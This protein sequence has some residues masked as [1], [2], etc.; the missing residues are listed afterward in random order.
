MYTVAGLAARLISIITLAAACGTVQG[1]VDFT[2]NWASLYHEDMPERLPG[3][4]L[5]DSSGI[6]VNAAARLRGDSYDA[7]RISA[8]TEYQCR[9]HGGDYSMRGL[10]NMRVEQV[11]DPFSQRLVAIKTRMNFQDMQ[12]TIWLDGREHPDDLAP[13]TW[14]GFST[15]TWDAN[16]LNVYTTHLKQNYLRRNGLPRSDKATFTEHWVRHGDYLTV[17][18]VI[19]DP[20]FLTEP[21]VR[22]QSWVLDPGQQLGR[23]TCEYLVEFPT[24]ALVP[25]ILPGENPYMNLVPDWYGL[26]MDGVR[27]G[28]ETIYPEY[29]EQIVRP[30]NIPQQCDR[31]CTCGVNNGPCELR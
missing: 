4:E 27:G 10:S 11:L 19:R 18:T 12:R 1:Q 28:A 9:P 15:G 6:P 14:Q 26:P 24:E 8:V 7:G 21:L 5:G 3:P 16:M 13:H 25:H 31:Y 29:I 30:E 22:S 17:T 20:A 2:G 23:A